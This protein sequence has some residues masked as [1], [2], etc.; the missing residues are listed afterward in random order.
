MQGGK[1]L[2]FLEQSALLADADLAAQLVHT[3]CALLPACLTAQGSANLQG[4]VVAAVPLENSHLL[5][6][7]RMPPTLP[8]AYLATQK[9]AHLQGWQSA[10]CIVSRG[11]GLCLV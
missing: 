3:L 8:L 1:H 7:V 9:G 6:N 4:E 10:V 5:E 2:E 11:C